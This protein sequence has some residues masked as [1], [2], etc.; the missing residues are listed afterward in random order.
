MSWGL[1][2]PARFN[3]LALYLEANFRG[4]CEMGINS[5]S[6]VAAS[7]V[8]GPTSLGMVRIYIEADGI[9][10]PMDFEPHEAIEIA[11]E[12]RAA[13]EKALAL[14]SGPRGQGGGGGDTPRPGGKR[15]RGGRRG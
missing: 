14:A 5:E 7:L 6:D 1:E 11:D 10:V 13:A 2:P 15:G 3:T 9:E 8:I 4:E 12:L